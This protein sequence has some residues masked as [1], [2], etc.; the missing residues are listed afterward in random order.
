MEYK[1]VLFASLLLLL[2]VLAGCS[3]V[4]DTGVDSSGVNSS[5]DSVG[6]VDTPEQII[7]NSILNE[8]DDIDD[9]GELF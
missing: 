9:L 7:D 8:S 2:L 5:G 6:V 4:S 3:H 1:R